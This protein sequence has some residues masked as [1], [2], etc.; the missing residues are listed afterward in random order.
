VK[1]AVKPPPVV[2][3]GEWEAAH[4][5]LLAKEKAATRHRDSLAAERRRLPR[6]RFRNDYAFETPDGEA[7]LRRGTWAVSPSSRCPAT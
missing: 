1:A 2:T 5:E 4:Q 6:V 7:S 3:P